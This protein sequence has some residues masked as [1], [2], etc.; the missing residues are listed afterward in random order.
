MMPPIRVTLHSDGSSDA[1]LL[2]IIDWAIHQC[3]PDINV[4]TQWADLRRL[5]HPPRGLHERIELTIELYPC[6][7]LC[8]HRDAENQDPEL[9]YQEIRDAIERIQA[10]HPVVPHV[11]VV[12]IRMQEAWL[13]ISAGAIRE[14]SGNPNGQV[15]IDLPPL[16]RLEEISDPKQLLFDL[17]LEASELNARRRKRLP[18]SSRAHRVANL[19]DDYSPLRR[20]TAFQEFE[21]ELQRTLP[22]LHQG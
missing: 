4:Q 10:S 9:R 18:V 6:D 2:P 8:I 1:R 7:L 16:D 3:A 21:A 22:Q 5:P 14:A 13:L 15:R 19:I 17:I 20:L 12:P 11:C